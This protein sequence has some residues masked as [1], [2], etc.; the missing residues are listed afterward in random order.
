MCLFFFTQKSTVLVVQALVLSHLDYYLVI[1]SSAAKKDL[2]KLQLAQNRAARLALNCTYRTNNNMH[3]CLSWLRVDEWLTASPSFYEKYYCGTFQV[4]LD[5]R[6][7]YSTD[8]HTYPIR[9]HQRSLHSPQVQNELKEMHSIIPSHDPME[10]LPSPITQANS[11][12]PFMA[13]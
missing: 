7:T 2:A 10:I 12:V 11:N 3:A 9:R 8:T 1:W 5:N 4:C 13:K 6:I